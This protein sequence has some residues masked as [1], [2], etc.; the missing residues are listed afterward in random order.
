[1]E[2]LLLVG[3][4]LKALS[5]AIGIRGYIILGLISAIGLQHV[6][7]EGLPI[8]R[9]IPLIGKFAAGR[10]QS[11]V[12]EAVAGAQHAY[13]IASA[14]AAAMAK[15]DAEAKS[16]REAQIVTDDFN[17]QLDAAEA[18][19]SEKDKD[20]KDALEQNA[21]LRRV[22]GFRCDPDDATRK[23]LRDHGF[24]FDP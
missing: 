4:L 17:R 23:L 11:A 21:A 20:L 6:Y 14:N 3:Q 19:D 12:N 9:S 22:N 15:A 7:Y 10:V 13:A 24:R 2:A 8:L 18:V 1:M 5:K 16:K